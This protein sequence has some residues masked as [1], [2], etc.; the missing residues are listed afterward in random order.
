MKKKLIL[1][2]TILGILMFTYLSIPNVYSAIIDGEGNYLT[3]SLNHS[4][5][6]DKWTLSVVL[7]SVLPKN[8]IDVGLEK[9]EIIELFESKYKK[10]IIESIKSPSGDD[11]IDDDSFVG[12]GSIITL[13]NKTEITV[14]LYGDVTCNGIV[15]ELDAFAI[16][17]YDCNLIELKDETK[18]AANLVK[19]N[20]ETQKQEDESKDHNYCINALDALRVLQYCNNLVGISE[21]IGL[22]IVDEEL[23]VEDEEI[24]LGKT[25]DLDSILND[26]IKNIYENDYFNTTYEYG[27]NTINGEIKQRMPKLNDVK[28]QIN[29]FDL[30][31]SLINMEEI[32]SAIIK[33]NNSQE[34]ILDKSENDNL[35][36]IYDWLS[37]NSLEIFNKEDFK[38]VILGDLSGKTFSV[39]V[40]LSNNYRLE[41]EETSKTYKIEF[42]AYPI[43]VTYDYGYKEEGK[44]ENKKEYVTFENARLLEKPEIPVREE[45]VTNSD[46][47]IETIKYKFLG[48][49]VQLPSENGEN[50][51]TEFDFERF[52]VIDNITIYARWNKIL[53]LDNLIL[54][55]VKNAGEND[56]FNTSY[57]KGSNQINVNV[58]QRMPKL[59]EVATKMNIFDILKNITNNKEIESI[60]ITANETD[61]LKLNSNNTNIL[62]DIINWMIKNSMQLFEK[63][64]LNEIII[65]DLENKVISVKVNLNNY[66]ELENGENSKIY[67]I[68][69]KAYPIEVTFDLRIY[70]K[71]TRQ[72][73]YSNTK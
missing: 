48:W 1:G 28:S 20:E 11:I 22:T 73:I 39:T 18:I 34:L 67:N 19:D 47:S 61:E 51:E 24:F 60:V 30:L 70:G 53:D 64:S 59:T 36:K 31:A 12:T 5:I 4:Q 62:D 32:D 68:S 52:I 66:V 40:N 38:D 35:N 6:D 57:E 16:V 69:F 27:I 71:W 58:K 43:E 37:D 72:K 15:D 17:K 50:V 54:N 42:K 41:N 44:S 7:P 8:E 33:A 45:K 26:E 25:I 46:G 9:K 21:E 29:T 56:Y 65:G 23:Y 63:E 3:C 55:E 10:N 2:I 14:I 13:K 49:Y